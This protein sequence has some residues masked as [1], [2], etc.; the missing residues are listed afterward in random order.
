MKSDLFRKYIWLA[1][2]IYRNKRV[3]FAEINRLWQSSS[4]SEGK[5]MALR[6]FHNHRAAIEELF[7]INIGCDQR[8]K[9]YFIENGDVAGRDIRSRVY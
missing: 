4:L 9:E 2:T 8:T 6:T 5:P 1:D 7:D 3:K